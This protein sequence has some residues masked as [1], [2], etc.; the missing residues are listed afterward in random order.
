MPEHLN[1]NIVAL[2]HVVLLCLFVSQKSVAQTPEKIPYSRLALEIFDGKAGELIYRNVIF[3]NDL[4]DEGKE[5]FM[6]D[7]WIPPKAHFIRGGFRKFILSKGIMPS[8]DGLYNI[9]KSIRFE[10]CTFSDDLRFSRCRFG[11][12]LELINV[13][14]PK[15]SEDAVGIEKDMGGSF[16]IDSCKLAEFIVNNPD[17]DQLFFYRLRASEFGFFQMVSG[18]TYAR[19]RRCNFSTTIF[20]M[21]CHHENSSFFVDSCSFIGQAAGADFGE[22]TELYVKQV[23]FSSNKFRKPGLGPVILNCPAANVRFFGNIFQTTVHLI[24]SSDYVRHD[25]QIV[26]S[27]NQFEKELMLGLESIGPSSSIF[28]DDIRNLNFGIEQGKYYDASDSAELENKIAFRR[29]QKTNKLLFDFYRSSGDLESANRMYVRIMEAEGRRLKHDYE[30]KAGFQTWFRYKLNRLLDFYTRYGTDPA[31]A[32][33]ISVYVLM[34]FA[35]LYF[36]FP[37]DW[38]IE[39]KSRLLRNFRDF[40][41]K[42]EKGYLKPFMFLIYGFLVSFF[43]AFFLSLNAFTTL[44]F[45]DIPTKGMARYLC[46]F[47]GFLGWFLLSMFTVALFNQAQF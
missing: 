38:D 47:Q 46:I 42:N 8:S 33:V 2:L 19:I 11:S 39:S 25:P 30:K 29:F 18:N 3:E 22:L 43:N 20:W 44:G 21:Q 6:T 24:L 28:P 10:N 37:S 4:P 9:R 5:Y 35:F 34:L 15:E 41:E 13:S 27:G 17:H 45:G 36:F 40:A 1:R 16:L 26:L 14:F 23:R 7:S 32:L 12:R 31:R